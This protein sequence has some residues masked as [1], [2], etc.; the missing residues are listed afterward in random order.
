MLISRSRQAL[1]AAL[2]MA[3]AG[4]ALAQDAVQEE[5]VA[6]VEEAASTD[7]NVEYVIQPPS[8]DVLAAAPADAELP[9]APL[10]DA[11][12]VEQVV[13]EPPY[14]PVADS[15]LPEEAKISEIWDPWEKFNRRVHKFNKVVD[16]R[17]ARPLAKAYVKVTPRVVRL[18]VSNFFNNLSMPVSA[19]NSLLQGKPRNA[20]KNLG[21]FLVN[22]TLGL[23]GIIDVATD[24]KITPRHED[25][26]QTMG[27]WGWQRSRYL[28]LPFLGP[29]TIRDTIGMAADAP[30][31]P[32]RGLKNDATRVGLQGVNL[33]N[34]RAELLAIDGIAEGIEDDYAL[35]RDTWSRRRMYQI[36]S[37]RRNSTEDQQLPA[38]LQDDSNPQPASDVLPVIQPN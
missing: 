9:D 28:E 34:V 30:L 10:T 11:V 38:Y 2:L 22:S 1:L 16:R 3:P 5:A 36:N 31:S 12:G 13:E 26:G 32:I 19:L 17:I 27:A 35:M 33:V 25:F 24:A 14:D 37:D 8:V 29:R 23:G 6:P 15:T 18:G 20:S 7:E 4:F 21:R